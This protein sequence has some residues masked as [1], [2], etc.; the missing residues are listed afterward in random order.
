MKI[1]V[2]FVSNVNIMKY[3]VRISA[4]SKK[5]MRVNANKTTS[6]KNIPIKCQKIFIF[7]YALPNMDW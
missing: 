7:K 4:E 3:L 5:F 6:E 2:V 1:F